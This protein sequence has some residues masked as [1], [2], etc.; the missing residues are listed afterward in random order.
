M[1]GGTVALTVPV[2]PAD[3]LIL[4]LQAAGYVAAPDNLWQ[5]ERHVAQLLRAKA[6]EIIGSRDRGFVGSRD[7]G[8]AERFVATHENASPQAVLDNL[9]SWDPAVLPYIQDL[10]YR[11]RAILLERDQNGRLNAAVWSRMTLCVPETPY[12]SRDVLILVE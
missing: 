10:P 7:R 2:L 4:T 6:H 9:G 5:L 12:T 8:F 3:Y 1:P 11:V